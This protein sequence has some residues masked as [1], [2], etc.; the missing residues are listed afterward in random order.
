MTTVD[1]RFRVA[2]IGTGVMG[3]PMARRLLLAGHSVT[4]WNRTRE[5]AEPLAS[6]GGRI[7]DTPAEAVRGSEIVALMLEDGH[8]VREV[9]FDRGVAQALRPGAVVVDLSSISPAMAREHADRLGRLGV[10]HLDAPVSGGVGGARAGTLA[11]MVGGARHDYE[12][13]EGLLSALGR[14]TYVGPPGSGQIAKLANQ[15]IV[16]ITIGAV[17]E[18]LSLARLA[19]V[20]PAAVR[21][22]IRGGFADGRILQEHGQ[23]MLDHDFEP[24]GAVRLQLKDL[25]TAL[26][27]AREVG[28]SLPI[29]SLVTSLF[30]RLAERGYANLDHSALLLEIEEA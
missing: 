4:A 10:G 20:D 5:K 14:P 2:F 18:G 11:V 21:E 30:E 27:T 22:A 23:R 8:V 25:L 3:S 28:L 6:V 9:L 1:G 12:R 24:G 13:A 26:S 16:G 29:T 7:A 19:G 15:I 17:A